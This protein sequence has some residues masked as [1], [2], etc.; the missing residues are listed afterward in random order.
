MRDVSELFNLLRVLL[1]YMPK[2][3]SIICVADVVWATIG[4]QS[5]QHLSVQP[6]NHVHVILSTSNQVWGVQ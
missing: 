4:V 2:L 6:Q 3:R 5:E 1:D